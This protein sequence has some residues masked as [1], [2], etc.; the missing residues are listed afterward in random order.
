MHFAVIPIDL[1]VQN[2]LLSIIA[3]TH[4]EVWYLA[5]PSLFYKSLGLTIQL[6]FTVK[7]NY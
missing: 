4:S 7:R 3:I 5:I 2:M 1:A 6:C